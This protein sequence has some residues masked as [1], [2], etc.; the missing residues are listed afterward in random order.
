MKNTMKIIWKYARAWLLVSV[1][2]IAF[3]FTATMV[4][5][6]NDFLAGTIDTVMGGEGRRNV[7]GDPDKYAYFTKTTD[8]FSQFQT[9]MKL[10]GGVISTSADKKTV[11][12][13]AR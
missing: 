8:G 3:F 11:L 6:Q 5:T 12:A 2:V 7:K 4:A 1:I 13:E 10:S 9:D